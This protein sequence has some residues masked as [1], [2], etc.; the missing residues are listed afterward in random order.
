MDYVRFL[1]QEAHARGLA[2]GLKNGGEVVDDVLDATDFVV[3]EQCL[4]YD[5]CETWRPFVDAG[6]AVFHI[7]YTEEDSDEPSRDSSAVKKICQDPSR[8]GFSTLIKHM[9]LDVWGVAC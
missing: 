3:N 2:I 9:S 6:K 4:Q 8:E 1:A 7:E 5:E